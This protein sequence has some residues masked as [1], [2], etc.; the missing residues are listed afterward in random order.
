MVSMINQRAYWAEWADAMLAAGAA[1][2]S[3]AA[4]MYPIAQ[5]LSLG[6]KVTD[7][8]MDRL[9]DYVKWVDSKNED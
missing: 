3:Q 1:G 9:K 7:R 2:D 4:A 8:D 6:G 5:W